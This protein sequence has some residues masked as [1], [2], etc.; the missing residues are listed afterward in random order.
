MIFYSVMPMEVVF[1]G[2]D[3]LEKQVLQELPVGEATMLVQQT[4]PYE[5]RLVR[6]ISPN[7]QDYLN[8]AYAPG[9]VIRFRPERFG[10]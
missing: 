9:Q 1:E 5:G 2:M 6:L 4:G 3:Q 7:P 10:E 8:P